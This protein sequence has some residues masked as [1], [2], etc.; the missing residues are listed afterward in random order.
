MGAVITSTK[1][2]KGPSSGFG[3]LFR[4]EPGDTFEILGTNLDG[5][6][7]QVRLPDGGEGWIVAY[8]VQRVETTV[9][10]TLPVTDVVTMT[11]PLESMLTPD[12]TMAVTTTAAVEMTVLPT[13]E[14]LPTE[15]PTPQ[16]DYVS[17]L[18]EESARRTKVLVGFILIIAGAGA[19]LVA[20]ASGVMYVTSRRGR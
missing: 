5:S 6:W 3:P 16:S 18:P 20:I 15:T 1:V 9:E 17:V 14:L 4:V 7:Y 13:A 2:R 19:F 12:V 11:V 8:K 10:P